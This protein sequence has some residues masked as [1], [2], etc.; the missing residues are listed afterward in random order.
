MPLIRTI[1]QPDVTREV[2]DQEAAQLERE[3]LLLPLELPT[4][5][6]VA[7]VVAAVASV[8]TPTPAKE[9]TPDGKQGQ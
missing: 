1:F 8:S 9:A 3:G 4:A 6:S 2:D 7:A 5:P